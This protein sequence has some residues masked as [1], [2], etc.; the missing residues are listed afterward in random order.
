MLI[1]L[2]GL[3][4]IGWIGGVMYTPAIPQL[5]RDLGTNPAAAQFTL[6]V[7]LAV[8][9]VSQ[10]IY[11]PLS[12]RYGRRWVLVISLLLYGVGS[13]AVA[14]SPTIEWM[15][16]ARVLQAFGAVG[17]TILARAIARDLWDFPAVRRPIA[18]INSGGSLAPLM[19]LVAGGFVA[20]AL[21]WQGIFWVTAAI[22]F[23]FLGAAIIFLPETHK[24]RDATAYGGL[25]MLTNYGRLLRS[26]LF[27][28]YALSQALLSGGIFGFMTGGPFV[29]IDNLGISS[30]LYGVLTAM[31]PGG[32]IIGNLL[33]SRA[34]KRLSI[35]PLVVA[36]CSLAAVSACISFAF[37]WSGNLNLTI[38]YPLM[39][40]YTVGV[41]I[42]I[43]NAMAGAIE[44][45]PKI[46]GTGAALLGATSFSAMSLSSFLVGSV[47]SG[48][49]VGMTGM[50]A[51]LSV[52]GLLFAIASVF[53]S[54]RVGR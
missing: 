21:G 52:P 45:D 15:T 20:N 31:L 35:H 18:L 46:A 26:P 36:G 28:S 42:N 43:P 33:A 8:F 19:A 50:L 27:M 51:A 22:A 47:E 10:L 40:I 38:I 23:F 48:S 2:A 4:A 41:G 32:F 44:V 24:E 37:V 16:L 30:S 9:A 49:G 6:T 5:A 29:I 12:D 53:L 7:F 11:G 1:L 13:V 25:R 14:L 54:R 17:G 39:M 3:S 34:S